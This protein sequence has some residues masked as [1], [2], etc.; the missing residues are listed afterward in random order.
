MLDF[1]S[2]LYLGLRHPSGS[3]RPWAQFTS[4]RPAALATPAGQ[5]RIAQTLAELQGC[6]RA[7]LSPSTLHLFWDLFGMLARRRVAVYMDAGTYPIARWGVEQAAARGITVRHFPHDDPEALER[8]LK[9]D[10]PRRLRPIVVADGFCPGCGKPAPIADYLK[11]TQAYG[12]YLIVDDTQA[13]GILGHSPSSRVPYGWD[14]GGSLRWHNVAGSDVLMVSSLAKGF[15]VPVALLAGSNA[16]VQWFENKSET[17]THCSPPS[18]AVIHA[19]EHA[20]TM[21]REQGDAIRLRLA[22]RVSRFRRQLAEY[23]FSTTGRLFPVQTLMPFTGVDAGMLHERLLRLG[24]RTVLH[25]ARNGHG[26][27]L[28]FLLN[29]L[30]STDDIDHA[31]DA[32]AFAMRNAQAKTQILEVNHELRTQC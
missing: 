1:T 29:V 25:R 2:A 4:G 14:G 17:R 31:A 22:Q 28:S 18:I 30:H 12:G 23:G 16:M 27:R 32:L 6:E 19:A 13:M 5:V 24:I 10:A 20:L 15:G 11:S 9:Q 7:T 21:N 8:R 26:A 3:L